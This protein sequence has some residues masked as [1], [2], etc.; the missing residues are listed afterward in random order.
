MKRFNLDNY[1]PR[2]AAKPVFLDRR[3]A[4]VSISPGWAWLIQFAAVAVGSASG[5]FVFTIIMGML[6]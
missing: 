4:P 5:V 1:R 2:N 3:P 6:K